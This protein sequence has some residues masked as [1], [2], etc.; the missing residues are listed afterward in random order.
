[1]VDSHWY[2]TNWDKHPTINDNCDIKTKQRFLDEYNSLIKK[3]RGKTTI[4]ALHH[5]MYTNGPHGGQYS[6]KSHITPLPIL[7]TLKNMIRETSGV[8]NVDLQNTMY[9]ELKRRLVTLAQANKKVIFVS[10]HEH[11]LQYL[12]EDNLRQIISGSG[13]KISEVRTIGG[14]KFGYGTLGY[15]KFIV[16][17]DGS[18]HVS[19]YS[20]KEDK[21][22]YETQV[23]DK[24]LPNKTQDFNTN[25]SAYTSAS[26]YTDK[27][28][29]VSGF[30]KFLWGDRYR[31]Y[32]STKVKAPNVMLDTLFGGL[33]PVRKGGGNQSKSLRLK[34]KNG[35][36]YVMRALRKQALQYLQ[37]VLFKDQY[38]EGQFDDTATEKLILDV[39][40]GS[41]PYA[42]FVIGDLAD[43]IGVYHTNPVLYYV[44]KQSQLGAYNDEFGDEL[45]MIEEHTSE[46][47]GG[48]A[49]FGFQNKLLST[50]DMMRKVHE[51]EDIIVDEKAYIKARLFDMLI[52][53]WD[54]HQDQWRWI[55][56]KENGKKIYRPMP[57]DRDQ[58]FSRM[59]DG[60]LLSSAVKLIPTAR[61]L[62]SY[63]D[64]LQDVKGIN[65]EP[66]PLDMEIITQ[67][68]K[69]VWSTQA[70][71]IQDNVTD[72]IIEKA[73]L[74]MPKEVR[75][76]TVED[77][78]KNIK[79]QTQ[80]SFKNYR[81]LL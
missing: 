72:A 11:N 67:S 56:F 63:S 33:T 24:N 32:Y 70:K 47:H 69:E 57:R 26:I 80:K 27:E 49:S 1:M 38:I 55:E 7:G 23:F 53:D 8:A 35:T 3:A 45:Y 31:T 36:Q 73:F 37:A 5:P 81:T 28:T 17:K 43:A 21:V 76:N 52:G 42:P 22:V 34:D 25:I 75:D 68:E 20:A 60:A 71:Y 44:P 2:I 16:Y 19:F 30:H 50:D 74:N 64:D 51:D 29:D 40:T 62:R 54:R 48:K 61:L 12:I 79:S 66:Y 59:S 4:V 46:G 78:K 58:A 14:G 15:A 41:H 18:S 65:V 39:F 77:I 6:F 13:S 10:G 9:N